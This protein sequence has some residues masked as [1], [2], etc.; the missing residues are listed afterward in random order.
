MFVTILKRRFS[1][2]Y[3]RKDISTRYAVYDELIKEYS[4]TGNNLNTLTMKNFLLQIDPRVS[5]QHN[6]IS[7]LSQIL[8]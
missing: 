8:K 6:Y 1:Q 4:H 7:K 3:K 2:V 5:R